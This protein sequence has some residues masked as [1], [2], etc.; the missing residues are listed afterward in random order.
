M[1]A[2][3]EPLQLGALPLAHRVVMAPLTRFRASDDHVHGDLAVEYYAQRA[4]VPGTFLTT[5]ATFI[6]P[7]A[8]GYPNV[9]GIY[10]QQQIDSW[11]KITDAVHAKGSYIFVQLW[12]LGRAAKPEIVNSEAGGDWYASSSATPMAAGIPEPRELK[13]EEIWGLVEDYAQAARNSIEAGFDGVEIHGANGYLI[14]QFT[15][16]IC[17]KRT[18]AW[19][20]SVENRSRFGL[21]VAKAVVAAIGAE[22]VGIRLSPFS[23][24]QT[25]KMADPIPQ[26]TH[27][28]TGLKELK[29]AY[30]HMV[31]SRISGNADVESTEKVDFA[32]K[33]WGD[34]SPVLIAGGFQ[35]DSAR[36]AMDEYSGYNIAIVFGRH[37]ISNP[38]LPFRIQKGLELTKYNR[39]TFYKVKSPEGYV[40][41]PFSKEWEAQ[42]KL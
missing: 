29:L 30:L 38:D 3:F 21:E 9:P 22:R 11:K 42:S 37:F 14:D 40:D 23:T 26:F 20:G 15:Q 7:R 24:F 36:R 32:L 35:P 25:M 16:D 19:G 31:E 4:S 39:D 28:I 12:A 8:S 10:N 41:Y 17:N 13:E 2:L 6:S 27:L 5:E 1:A 18:D 33:L 34:K